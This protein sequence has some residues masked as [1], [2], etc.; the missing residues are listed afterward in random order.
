MNKKIRFIP[1]NEEVALSSDKS[2]MEM[3]LSKGLPIQSSCK[4]MATCGECRVFLVEGEHNVLPPTSKELALIGQG[5]YIDR[6]RLSC[7]LYC[8]GEVTVDLKEQAEKAENQK[9]SKTFL[10]RAGKQNEQQVRSIG[11]NFIEKASKETDS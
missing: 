2:V 1:Q 9:I 5:H 7:Q 11:D 10:K 8:F 6:R 4:G 3:A